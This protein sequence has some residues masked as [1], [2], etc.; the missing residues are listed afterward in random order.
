MANDNDAADF[1]FDETIDRNDGMIWRY[2]SSFI[3]SNLSWKGSGSELIKVQN[4]LDRRIYAV[5]NKVILDSEQGKLKKFGV[6]GGRI[7]H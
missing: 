2:W 7:S 1:N 6:G 4:R 5:K 3:G